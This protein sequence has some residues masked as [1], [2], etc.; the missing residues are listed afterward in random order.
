MGSRSFCSVQCKSQVARC[1]RKSCVV[2][3]WAP[4]SQREKKKF[5]TILC[6]HRAQ[7]A[8]SSYLD[9][10]VSRRGRLAVVRGSEREISRRKN[11]ESSSATGVSSRLFPFDLEHTASLSP[12]HS[13]AIKA[14]RQL[15]F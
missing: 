3:F 5:S 7:K 10:V 2:D 15:P 14:E 6:P 12:A 1:A 4:L 11:R 9:H 13:T 8:C